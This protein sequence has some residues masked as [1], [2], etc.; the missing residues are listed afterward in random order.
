MPI[1][2]AQHPG[3]SVYDSYF[4]AQSR[5]LVQRTSGGGG[6]KTR[7]A[8]VAAAAA[9]AAPLSAAARSGRRTRTRSGGGSGRRRKRGRK[10][11]PG[12]RTPGSRWAAGAQGSADLRLGHWALE[13][14]RGGGG[15]VVIWCLGS[16]GRSSCIVSS[17]GSREALGLHGFR[18]LPR[19]QGGYWR[20][21]P[22]QQASSSRCSGVGRAVLLGCCGAVLHAL[23]RSRAC[24]RFIPGCLCHA[25]PQ[26]AIRQEE[27]GKYGIIRES[28]MYAKRPEF[29]LWAAEVGSRGQRGQKGWR[30]EEVGLGRDKRERGQE[31]RGSRRVGEEDNKMV[32]SL[33]RGAWECMGGVGGGRGEGLAWRRRESHGAHAGQ[34]TNH[35]PGSC[36]LC[37]T[38][39]LGFEAD[40]GKHIHPRFWQVV[41]LPQ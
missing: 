7:S 9:A 21:K 11:R 23:C 3:T 4:L 30:E 35:L 2:Q 13:G 40:K 22:R 28:D 12:P 19:G 33:R 10:R 6:G 14:C 37:A 41:K 16:S 20:G 18:A 24:Q 34:E 17:K 27:Y 1:L 5:S 39:E 29:M 38:C 26:G 36:R 32:W 15:S 31:G 8:G 25:W